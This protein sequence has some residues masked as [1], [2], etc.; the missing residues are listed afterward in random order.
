MTQQ[1]G[2]AGITNAI[3][4][5][6]HVAEDDYSTSRSYQLSSLPPHRPV[7]DSRAETGRAVA[8]GPRR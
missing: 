3:V 2:P 6:R 1:H 5:V 4:S 8:P 7:V